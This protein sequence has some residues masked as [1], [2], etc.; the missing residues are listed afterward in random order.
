MRTLVSGALL[1]LVCISPFS[2][3][4]RTWRVE[5][6]GS[7]DFTVIQ[8]C[9]NSSSSGDTILIGAGRYDDWQLYGGSYQY[10]AR[11]IIDDIDLTIIGNPEG[12][13]VIGPDQVYSEQHHGVV[14]IGNATIDVK[15]LKFENL[16]GGLMS[17][18]GGS[19]IV[20]NCTF[21][22][23]NYGTYL[24]GGQG[25]VQNCRF[26]FATNISHQVLSYY[27]TRF[28]ASYCEIEKVGSLGSL[29]HGVDLVACQDVMINNC[30]VSG[31]RTGIQFDFGTRANIV[32]C[33]IGDISGS[34]AYIGEGGN[35]VHF[36]ECSIT[37]SEVGISAVYPGFSLIVES[38]VFG[39]LGTATLVGNYLDSGFFRNNVLS[40]GDRGVVVCGTNLKANEASPEIVTDYD[41]KENFW[42]TD[43]PDSI[44]AWIEDN[45]DDPT[46]NYRILWSP[47]SGE[48]VSAKSKSFGGVKSLFR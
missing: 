17:W 45:E 3:L 30:S 11:V 35:S 1:V 15:C 16:Y 27:Q 21:T 14:L 12:G 24:E 41:M 23:C 22:E 19:V 31:M 37:N 42:G 10:P 29:G 13:T 20:E 36:A 34:A 46:I 18:S 48:P 38:T 6:D 39:D 32:N 2:A 9:V 44:Q 25:N 26:S 4:C 33:Q 43:I 8:D 47:F 28:S 7:G 40:R 5:K